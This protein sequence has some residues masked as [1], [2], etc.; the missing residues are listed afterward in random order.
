M[1]ND[2]EKMKKQRWFR[3]KVR[4]LGELLRRLPAERQEEINNQLVFDSGNAQKT[5]SVR[6]GCTKGNGLPKQETSK[7]ESTGL[8][9]HPAIEKNSE[10]E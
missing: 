3:E 10:S 1:T 5:C 9:E 6:G 8:P 4:E 7:T 2:I